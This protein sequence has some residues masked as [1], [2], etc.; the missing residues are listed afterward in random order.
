MP[1]SGGVRLTRRRANGSL[2]MPSRSRQLMRDQRR[3]IEAAPP[4]PRPV[5][6]HRHQQAL[7]PALADQ[8]QHVARHGP[9]DRDLA[10]VF[11]ADRQAPRQFVIGDGGAGPRNPRRLS[12]AGGAGRF[13]RLKRQAAGRAAAV[14]EKF[15]LL[16]ALGAEAM[17]LGDD[18]AASGAARRK[19]EI[20]RRARA[21]IRTV[22]RSSSAA[23]R[24]ANGQR[25]SAAVPAELFDMNLRAL[26]RDR[27]SRTGPNSS[28]MNA[29][30][31]IAS[32][33]SG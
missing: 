29:P 5:E 25:T 7:V 27:A 12:K 26:R 16:P 3:L 32:I 1:F 18:R 31:P 23:C 6:R 8:R 10:A 19:R 4:Q 13:G 20:E 9:R 2:A 14:A 30:S 28:S 17:H 22:G 24:P 33:V 21:I 11:Q 15:D